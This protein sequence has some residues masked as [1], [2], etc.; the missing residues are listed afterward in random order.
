MRITPLHDQVLVSLVDASTKTA[1]GLH[2]P[3][4]ATPSGP[5]VARVVA[6]GNGLLT[7]DG[8][9]VPL[10]VKAGQTVLLSKNGERVE[11]TEGGEKYCLVRYNAILAIKEA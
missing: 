11:I 8:K 1:G 9:R 3:E 5:I 10:D 6:V 2:I 4:T 7:H